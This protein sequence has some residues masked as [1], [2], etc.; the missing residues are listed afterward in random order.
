MGLSVNIHP[1]PVYEGQWN[2]TGNH[3]NCSSLEMRQPGGLKH[4]LDAVK[5]LEL[6]HKKHMEPEVYG[7][8]N[9][10]RLSGRFETQHIDKFSCGVADRGSSIRIQRAVFDK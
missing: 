10:L 4:I 1:K 6:N 7:R 2:G 8:D 5:K 9:E 3:C